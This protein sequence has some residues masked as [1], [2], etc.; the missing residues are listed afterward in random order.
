M[1]KKLG[2]YLL[3]FAL[4]LSCK[5]DF[6]KDSV[7]S[8]TGRGGSLA[9]FTVMN[10]YLYAVKA[11]ELLVF[12]LSEESTD[13]VNRIS[14]D[15][16]A[17]TIFPFKGNLLLG[18][19]TGMWVYDVSLPESPTFISKYEHILSC[20]PV[21]ADGDFAFTTLRSGTACRNGVNRLDVLNIGS[22]L[23][24]Y[25]VRSYSLLNPFGL[26]V[27]GNRLYVGEDDRGLRIFDLS[28]PENMQT[29]RRDFNIN[30][31]DI[32]PLENSLL[33]TASNGISQYKLEENDQ[34]TL[35]S[36][37]EIGD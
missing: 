15:A 8:E 29:V 3:F 33:I 19:Q 18:T 4:T 12:D 14:L 17:E 23:D 16:F 26:A 11:H 32:I 9:R 7:D 27:K 34:F 13:L 10:G 25:L 31:R 35:L 1:M 20:D 30:A 21:V 5:S 36:H 2:L 24:P 28:D 22:L 6:F 37:I